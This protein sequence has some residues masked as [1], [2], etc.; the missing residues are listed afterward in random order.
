MSS[1][2][3][4]REQAIK[5]LKQT[6]C[7]PQVINHCL[8]VTDLA[9]EIATKIEANGINVDLKLV[10]AGALLH[11]LGRSKS[12][13]VDHAVVGAEL[14]EELG[15]P[16]AVVRIIRRHVGGGI[17]MEEAEAFGWKKDVYAPESLEEKIVSFADKLIYHSKRV[18]IEHEV[19]L[20]EKENKHEAAQRVRRLHDEIS[21]LLGN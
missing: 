13:S 19:A 21:I 6:H 12:H 11:D 3:P 4:S 1:K 14:A 5:I 18:P 8:A 17:T 20:L 7:P 2:L 16:E 15:L 9:V 10:E